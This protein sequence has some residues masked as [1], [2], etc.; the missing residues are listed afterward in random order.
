MTQPAPRSKT[1]IIV[2]AGGTAALAFLSV[3]VFVATYHLSGAPAERLATVTSC[4]HDKG[5]T[6]I[7]FKVKN[8]TTSPQSWR[9]RFRVLDASGKEL[10]TDVEYVRTTDPGATR[11]DSIYLK[12]AA[13]TGATCE[14]VG[15]D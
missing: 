5:E 12:Y 3:L 11:D 9:L 15:E 7:G 14:Y 4:D 10:S 2:A 8:T 6:R 1:W 13:G